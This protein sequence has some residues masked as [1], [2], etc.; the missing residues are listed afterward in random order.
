MF[1]WTLEMTVHTNTSKHSKHLGVH[2]SQRLLLMI[3]RS[4]VCENLITEM[5]SGATSLCGAAL[6]GKTAMYELSLHQ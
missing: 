5:M 3:L 6:S 4:A 1:H 2:S